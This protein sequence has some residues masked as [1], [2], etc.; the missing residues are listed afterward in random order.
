MNLGIFLQNLGPS[1]SYYP[2]LATAMGGVTACI[3]YCQLLQWHSEFKNSQYWIKVSSDKIEKQTGLSITEQEMARQI[4]VERSLLQE[5]FV[6]NSSETREFL[7]DL[8]NFEKILDNIYETT[9]SKKSSPERF[10]NNSRRREI[11][12]DKYFGQRRQPIAIAVTP[13]YR[14]SGPW[15]SEEELKEFQRALEEYAR[16]NGLGFGNP[17]GWAFK[18]IDSI[19]KGLPSSFW[20][21]FVAGIPLGESQK[22]KRE[23]EIEPG[24]P[25]PAF[26]EERIQYYIQK[27]EPIE[28]AVAKA[29]AD[30]RNPV[31]GKDLW[32]GFLRKCDRIADEALKAKNLGITAPYLPPSFTDKPAITKESVIKKL[33]AINF[34]SP[35]APPNLTRLKPQEI[36]EEKNKSA[37][38]EI[39]SITAL[40]AAYKTPMGKTFV[41]RQIAEHPEW[42]Y[43][44][45]DGQIVEI[46]PF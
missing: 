36:E 39:P 17:S 42:G 10:E 18:V 6:N 12:T 30:L 4:L 13:D 15:K 40:Q 14:F 8:D 1:Y 3:F 33:E 24:V 9:N 38:S 44:I 43:Q 46:I 35:Q 20:D 23:W 25:Y 11:K 34:Q 29:R 28:A 7:L 26:E 32:E 5:R 19:S 27:G 31:L 16:N 41:E 2:K 22:I 21:D 37:S 45:I